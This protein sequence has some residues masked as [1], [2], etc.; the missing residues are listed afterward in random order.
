MK[1]TL[2]LLSLMAGLLFAGSAAYAQMLKELVV[3][4][5]FEGSDL[6]NF[7]INI[8]NGESQNLES[9]DIVV[10]DDDANNHCAKISFTEYPYKT[11][12]VITLSEPLTE[13][14]R[15]HL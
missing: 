4:G 3:N 7:A 9:D 13:G 15:M 5:D 11:Q 14:D 8:T 1:R 12:F 2:Q 10:D 6:S